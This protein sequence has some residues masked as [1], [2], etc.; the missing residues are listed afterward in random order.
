MPNE[1]NENVFSKQTGVTTTVGFLITL[2]TVAT[3]LAAGY[4]ELRTQV[5]ANK[6]QTNGNSEVLDD[7]TDTFTQILIRLE[8]IDT[9]LTNIEQAI[10]TSAVE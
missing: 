7:R 10:L 5:S 8:N 2:I 3:V 6:V 9:R 1:K 4:V